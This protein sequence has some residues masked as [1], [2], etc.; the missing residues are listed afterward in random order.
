MKAWQIFVHSVRQVFGNLNGA[1]RVSGLLY[2]AQVAVLVVFGV[3]AVSDQ[4]DIQHKMMSGEVSV[5]PILLGMLVSFLCGLWIAV[6]WHRYVLLVEEPGLV[7]PFR[8]DRMLG[9]LGR[10]IIIGVIAVLLGAV[11]GSLLAAVLLP[12]LGFSA[13]GAML[14]SLLVGLPVVYV[15]YR[16]SVGLPASAVGRPLGLGEAW[17]ATAGE[18]GTLIGL[19]VLS[20]VASFALGLPAMILAEVPILAFVWNI[21]AGWVQL[22]VGVSILTTLYGHYVEKRALV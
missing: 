19:A 9:Y 6:G 18:S 15:I 8:G 1:L 22:M 21:G 5:A 16:L 14:F 10:S 12:L 20:L 7:P 2:L 4:A 13:G 17:A 3:Y 11:V